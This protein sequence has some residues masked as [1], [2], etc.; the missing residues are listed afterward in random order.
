MGIIFL[1]II[2]ALFLFRHQISAWIRAFMA[3][4]AEDMIRKMAGMPTR[5]EEQRRAKE[6]ARKEKA[7]SS[8]TAGRK[9]NR[10]TTAAPEQAHR[11]MQ[12]YA[13]DVEYTEIRE[14]ESVEIATETHDGKRR[15]VVESQISD[16]EYTEIKVSNK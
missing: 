6:K 5:K 13:E 1:L 14:F 7:Q 2:I 15:V 11:R 16:V 9:S 10:A 8:R 3:R 4:R 12:E